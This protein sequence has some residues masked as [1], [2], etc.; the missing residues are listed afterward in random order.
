[1][2]GVGAV[3]LERL[4]IGKRDDERHIVAGIDHRPVRRDR[5]AGEHIDH[6]GNGP[7][8]VA[9]VDQRLPDGDVT[10]LLEPHQHHVLNGAA[11]RSRRGGRSGCQCIGDG[12]LRGGGD[13]PLAFIPCRTVRPLRPRAK[14]FLPLSPGFGD[15][16]PLAPVHRRRRRIAGPAAARQ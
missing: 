3:R 14:V 15:R 8:G 11:R 10:G 5:L 13:L 12:P 7:E 2:H 16:W 4:G 6:A 1:V 9:R